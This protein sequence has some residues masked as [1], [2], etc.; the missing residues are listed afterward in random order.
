MTVLMDDSLF[1]VRDF[2][3]DTHVADLGNRVGHTYLS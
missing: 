2:L 1:S 3:S